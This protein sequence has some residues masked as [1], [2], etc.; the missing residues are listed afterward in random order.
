MLNNLMANFIWGGSKEKRKYHL[1]S[2]KNITFPKAL[3][4]WGI[5]D[6]RNFGRALLCKSL[7]RGI[8]GDSFWSSII[9]KKYMGNKYLIFWYRKGSIGNPHGSAI[10]Q[11]FWKIESFFLKNLYW[12]VQNG[13][14]VYIGY[15]HIMGMGENFIIPSIIIKALHRKGIFTW[16]QIIAEWQGGIPIWKDLQVLGLNEALA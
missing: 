2:L 12:N 16:S 3:G 13:R 7:W 10:W 14:D 9:R 6:I 5:I 11:S 15:D 1:T 8:N 4:G